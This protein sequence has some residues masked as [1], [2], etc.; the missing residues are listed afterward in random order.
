P[1]QRSTRAFDLRARAATAGALVITSLPLWGRARVGATKLLPPLGDQGRG[2]R[3][4]LLAILAAAALTLGLEASLPHFD[5]A[6]RYYDWF[7]H[8]D[9]ARVFQSATAAG[10]GSHWGDATVTTRTPLYNLLGSVALTVFGDRFTVFQVLTAA[11]AWL[12]ILPLPCWR[13]AC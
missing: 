6:E 11:V 1:S 8:F 12:W 10:L 5:L 9:L 2:T 13:A 7:V 4:F 3:P